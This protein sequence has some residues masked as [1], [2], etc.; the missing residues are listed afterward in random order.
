MKSTGEW[1]EW[2]PVQY[3]PHYCEESS[4]AEFMHDIPRE[5]ARK[6]G[7]LL[8]PDSATRASEKREDYLPDKFSESDISALVSKPVQCQKTGKLFNLQR[9]E[10]EFYLKLGIPIPRVHWNEKMQERINSREL[11][12]AV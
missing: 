3:A 10:L 12:P 4:W 7:Y 6:R 2:F 1:G 9:R 11:V 8:L 5:V